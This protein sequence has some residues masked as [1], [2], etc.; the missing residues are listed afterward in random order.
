MALTEV[1][2]VSPPAC[3]DEEECGVGVAP[4]G[5]EAV[6]SAAETEGCALLEG[7]E[8]VAAALCEGPPPLPGSLGD[9]VALLLPTCHKLPVAAA[10]LLANCE[11]LAL[12]VVLRLGAG[13]RVG[14]GEAEEGADA[15]A[16]GEDVIEARELAEAPSCSEAVAE[17]GPPDG[18]MDEEAVGL[19]GDAVPLTDGAALLAVPHP[20][21]D[22]NGELEPD[23]EEV[24]EADGK[25]DSEDC[26]EAL[27]VAA[28]ALRLGTKGVAETDGEEL[29][30]VEGDGVS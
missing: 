7:T 6:L 12:P 19:A 1:L 25:R 10:V 22:A 9:A 5:G 28:A 23:N 4:G 26:A 27:L 16:E 11:A 21:A 8:G 3:K 15:T 20:D 29:L 17:G 14:K 30:R 2:A 18:E 13:E 24:A